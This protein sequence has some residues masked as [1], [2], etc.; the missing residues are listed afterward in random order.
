VLHDLA[1]GETGSQPK[2]ND[3]SRRRA[4]DQ[5]ERVF[6]TYLEVSFQLRQYVSSEQR[7]GSSTI[8]GK[9]LET[10]DR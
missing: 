5:V 6:D 9:D 1:W 8:K 7:F 4:S 3:A 10:I 2:R